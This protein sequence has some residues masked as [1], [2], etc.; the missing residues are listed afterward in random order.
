M[1]RD[2][3]VPMSG[4]VPSFFACVKAFSA[5]HDGIIVLSPVYYPFFRAAEQNGRKVVSINL[6]EKNRNYKID[7]EKLEQEAQKK[8]NSVLLFCSPHNPVGRVW[9]KYE[10]QRVADICKKNNVLVIS[11]EIHFDLIMPGFRHHVFS[12]VEPDSVILTAPSK[13]F[14]IAGLQCSNMIIQNKELRERIKK[15]IST[16]S[17][18]S[19]NCLGYT[20]CKAA[21][22]Y[23]DEWLNQLLQVINYNKKTVEH[24]FEEKMPEVRTAELQGTYLQWWDFRGYKLSNEELEKILVNEA[25]LFPDM[26]YVFGPGGNGFIRVNLGCPSVKIEE[27][28]VRLE[29]AMRLH[30]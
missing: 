6:I 22:R 26:G 9:T 11:D 25:F 10:L 24:F 1:E 17:E 27:A 3:I 23:G 2:W 19:C 28:L 13:T 15:E 16:M 30:V 14:N 20:A 4:V 5:P 18:G 7:F 21:Y 29:K 12:E 8:E